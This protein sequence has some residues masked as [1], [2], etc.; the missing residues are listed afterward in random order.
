MTAAL[1]P[2]LALRYLAELEPAIEA[3]AVLGDDGAVLAGDGT[4]GARLVA[5]G[6]DAERL[7]SARACGRVVIALVRP[8]ALEG[9]VRHDLEM[10]VRSLGAG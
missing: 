5:G 8:G 10:V 6:P 7:L 4:L 9:L 3:V 1:T 2:E